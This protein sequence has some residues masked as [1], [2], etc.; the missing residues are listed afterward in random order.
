MNRRHTV[1]IERSD[2]HVEVRLAGELLAV[3]DHPVVLEETGLPDRYYVPRHDV[4]MQ[5][6][7]P[8]SFHTTCPLKGEASYWSMEIDGQ[9]YDG[10]AW[11]YETP[12]PAAAGI[13]G[14][15]SF[16]P[17]RVELLVDGRPLTD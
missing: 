4:Q 15:L 1:T 5:R 14:L 13:T 10:I 16:Y 9:T 2:A 7:R 12:I 3:T 6:L 8:A 17:E 11:S